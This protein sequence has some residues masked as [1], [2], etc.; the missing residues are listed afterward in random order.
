MSNKCMCFGRG[1]TGSSCAVNKCDSS[2]SVLTCVHL[3][4]LP[5]FRLTK[6]TLLSVLEL[7]TCDLRAEFYLLKLPGLCQQHQAKWEKH[8]LKRKLL[9]IMWFSRYE[10]RGCFDITFHWM[11]FCSIAHCR[12]TL[13]N[14]PFA[15]MRKM[16][17]ENFL[18]LVL[19]I[20][21]FV[22]Q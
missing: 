6:L 17:F 12:L 21:L 15:F 14:R 22:R 1:K 5:I 7:S 10:V 3:S 20:F 8:T 19:T 13:Q 4:S 16:F 11:H 9:G 2:T 18:V